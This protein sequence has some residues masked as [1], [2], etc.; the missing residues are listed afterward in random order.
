MN[1]VLRAIANLV[2]AAPVQRGLP[3]MGLILPSQFI[4]PPKPFRQVLPL[5]REIGTN[6]AYFFL[7]IQLQIS[8]PANPGNYIPPLWENNL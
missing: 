6:I 8:L 3:T 5:N 1:E 4:Y 7:S 2:G